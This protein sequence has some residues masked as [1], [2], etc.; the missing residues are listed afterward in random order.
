MTFRAENISCQLFTV[1]AFSFVEVYR[2]NTC[3]ESNFVAV[4]W[5]YSIFGTK[6]I[7]HEVLQASNEKIFLPQI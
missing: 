2:Y 3:N 6:F 5:L 7:K 1:N 4:T